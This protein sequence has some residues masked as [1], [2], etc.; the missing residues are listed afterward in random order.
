MFRGIF[1]LGRDQD[2]FYS[3][4]T[5]VSENFIGNYFY[6]NLH[7]AHMSMKLTPMGFNSINTTQ[8]KR[9]G[10]LRLIY[11]DWF[12]QEEE[13]LKKLQE[14]KDAQEAKETDKEYL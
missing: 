14:L 11:K 8:T 5:G 4:D 12:N 10:T 2:N 3:L 6:Y 9:F 1:D 13:R 7:E